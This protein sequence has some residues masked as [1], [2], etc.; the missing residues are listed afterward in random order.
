MNLRYNY[1]L[2]PN[3]EQE[4]FF[5][6]SCGAA[7]FTYNHFLDLNIK[8]YKETGKFIF[9]MDMCKMITQMKRNPEYKWFSEVSLGCLRFGIFNLDK[10]LKNCF[11]RGS[12]FP[13]FKKKDELSDRYGEAQNIRTENGF[14]KISK[15]S[16]VKHD[17]HRPMPS[18]I[19]NVVIKK[20]GTKWFV[21]CLVE[22][23]ESMPVDV[24][25][26]VGI[27]VGIKEFATLSTGE[28]V[29]NPKFLDKSLRVI[30][31]HQKSLA[32]KQKGSSNYKKAR[33]VLKNAH[34]KIK[35]KRHN[36]LHGLSTK[37]VRE[38]DLICT[39]DLN[40]VGMVK[41]RKLAKAISQL[42]WGDFI[43]M[44]EYKC[45]LYG[46][47][48]VKIGRFDPSSKTCNNC[49]AVKT[50]LSL[51]QRTFDCQCGNNIDRDLNASLNIRDWGIKKYADGLPACGGEVRRFLKT[52]LPVKQEIA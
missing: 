48:F 34:M 26:A 33:L 47:G 13:K 38:N 23:Q 6:N 24:K 2:Y 14:I 51:S 17:N 42:G 20:Q 25:S 10:A 16:L 22:K 7:R 4:Q 36:F 31:K 19:K 21:S 50:K 12:G 15:I 44:L 37:I 3:K 5:Q 9:Y 41:N 29:A 39:E 8:H 46:K 28:S 52:L 49:G 40:I 27:D 1:R 32:R 43:G 11:K 35:N 30:R 18:A 45:K